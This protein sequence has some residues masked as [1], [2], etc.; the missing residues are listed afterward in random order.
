MSMLNELA[1]TAHF[2]EIMKKII[3]LTISIFFVYC[4]SAQKI[5][6]GILNGPSAIP[7]AFLIEEKKQYE[8]YNPDFQIFSSA[9]LE[10]PKL[11]KGEIDLGILPPNAAAKLWNKSNGNIVV[12]A[13]VGNGNIYL[14]SKNKEIKK[15]NEL[16]NK[17][18]FCAGLGATPDYLFKYILSQSGFSEKEFLLD[19]SIPAP[20]LAPALISGK[21]DF[22]L[23][24]EPFATVAKT[25]SDNITINLNLSEEYKKIRKDEKTDFPMTV[26][27][28][29]KKNL[30]SLPNETILSFLKSYENAISKTNNNPS[31]AGRLV[32]KHTLGLNAEIAE[33]AIPN[34]NFI[35]SD[36]SH[37]KDQIESL[38]K[39]FY[40]LNPESI[41]GKLPDESFY[42]K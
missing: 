20:E 3:Y 14:L 24:P 29:N 38:L 21:A 26:L 27:V 12:L 42:Q 32:E 13:V 28:A 8:G 23:V 7:A 41:G 36:A 4:L 1:L 34:C 11:L 40:E 30:S 17:K 22:I 15:I 25:K 6:I 37:S 10:I 5:S 31:E 19:F 2:F 18:I 39:I 35:Y 33:K 9:D 16:K